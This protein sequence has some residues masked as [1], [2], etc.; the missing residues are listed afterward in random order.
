MAETKEAPAGGRPASA[1][2]FS[3]SALN[4]DG[5][6]VTG[7]MEAREPEA[8]R[9]ALWIR[10]LR[11]TEV[12]P[13]R[14]PLLAGFMTQL[15]TVKAQEVIVFCRQ[16]ATFVRVGI[17]ITTA[18]ETIGE[19]TGNRRMRDACAS[20]VA[21]LERGSL[22]STAVVQHPQVFPRLLSDLIKAAEVTGQVDEV[23]LRAAA[24]FEREADAKRKIRAALTYPAI[25]FLM[26][27]AVA[28]GLILFVLPRFKDLF[29]TFNAPLPPLAS[30]L[31][32]IS[33][34]ISMNLVIIL[35]AILV[36][37]L[38]GGAFFRS[39]SGRLFISRVLIKT[40]Y[41]GAMLRAAATERFC[42]SLSDALRA[43]VPVGTSF[44]VVVDSTR[45]VVFQKALR[46][47][48]SEIA[49]GDSFSR[50]LKRTG[51]FPPMVIQMV[52]VGEETGTLD[53]H[54]AETAEMYDQEL[55]FR[56][57]KLTSFVEPA[58]IVSVGVMVGIV[59]VSL[60]QAIY[61]FTA[62]IK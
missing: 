47:V 12:K 31:L 57:K 15:T 46:I 41:V 2:L 42:R 44:A 23:L 27:L 18:L 13:K 38:G 22:L 7:V 40:P 50:S 30:G 21:D 25:V 34:F 52:R 59:A 1:R 9:E 54:L 5:D 6:A 60:V 4:T 32:S 20:M 53:H 33:D 35:V 49:V 3:Y 10:G 28:I 56:L 26:A 16:L 19:G 48:G 51:L 14:R 29:A 43:G 45:N 37:V 36:A 58:L 62:A 24:H 39:E 61:G 11:P 8:V 17:P 55:E